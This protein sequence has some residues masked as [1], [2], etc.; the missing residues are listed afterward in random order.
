MDDLLLGRLGLAVVAGGLAL[1]YGVDT[2][3]AA[4][5]VGASAPVLLHAAARGAREVE[6]P[7][8]LPPVAEEPALHGDVL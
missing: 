3:G 4:V 7:Q 2:I 8:K 6:V 1:M 5:H